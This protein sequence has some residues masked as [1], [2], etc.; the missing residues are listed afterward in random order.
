TVHLLKPAAGLQPAFSTDGV[1]WKP[2]P[3]LNGAALSESLLVGYTLDKDGTAE[4]QT[5]VPGW[6]G[7]VADT[8]PPAA[9]VVEAR[10][11][12]QGLYLTWQP[13]ADAGGIASYTVLKNGMPLT[14]LSATAHV[15]AVRNPGGATANV[16][17]VR[18]TDT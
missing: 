6:F 15:A 11:V 7:L 18:A 9:P 13:A 2:V 1:T 16:Y 14:E 8:T 3:A 5:L 10:L 17:R 12:P 4:I